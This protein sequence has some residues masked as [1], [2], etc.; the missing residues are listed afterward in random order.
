MIVAFSIVTWN[1]MPVWADSFALYSDSIPKSW[2]VQPVLA[3]S[4]ILCLNGSAGLME[5]EQLLREASTRVPFA[6]IEAELANVVAFRTERSL[7]KT[8]DGPDD[9]FTEV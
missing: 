8:T 5:A 7:M 1:R 3:M 4:R 9:A 2:G 6:D